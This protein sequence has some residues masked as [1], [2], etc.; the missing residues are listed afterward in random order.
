M[1]AKLLGCISLL[2]LLSGCVA[3]NWDTGPDRV[4][5]AL[6]AQRIPNKPSG[7]DN[8]AEVN[9]TEVAGAVARQLGDASV[10]LAPNR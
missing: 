3:E 1:I 2:V 10:Q 8:A 7:E 6:E 9:A 5:M 4:S